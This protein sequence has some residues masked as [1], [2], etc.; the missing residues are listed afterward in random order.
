VWF[1]KIR[2]CL[3][4][5]SNKSLERNKIDVGVRVEKLEFNLDAALLDKFQRTVSKNKTT[6][7]N[8][9]LRFTVSFILFL[10]SL[11][12]LWHC[13]SGHGERRAAAEYFQKWRTR[14]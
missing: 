4:E 13:G 2:V 1:Q 8:N 12:S 3:K 11:F 6:K 9:R 10:V 5:L 14:I 7:P